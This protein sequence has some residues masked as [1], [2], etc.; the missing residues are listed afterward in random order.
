[1]KELHV[2]AEYSYSEAERAAV[3]VA[4][5]H[6]RRIKQDAIRSRKNAECALSHWNTLLW[7]RL[8]WGDF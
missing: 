7:F 1:M 6:G 5:G 8:V 4:T 3:S 2:G